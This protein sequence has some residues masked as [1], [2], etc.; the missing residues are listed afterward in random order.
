M[1]VAFKYRHYDK[2]AAS[3]D[4]SREPGIAFFTSSG[5]RI[6][7]YPK[8]HSKNL[9]A[10]HQATI[11]NF[12]KLVRVFKN[13]RGKLVDDGL[14]GK[15]IAPSYFIEGLLYNVPNDKFVG[16]YGTIVLNILQWLHQ[17]T[18]RSKFVCAN[19]QYYLLRDN[20]PVCWPVADGQQF[21]NAAI[22]LW[23]DW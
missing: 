12:K 16:S 18:D 19:E 8:Q 14:L 23:N 4:Q 6:A 11:N 7:N 20:E 15:G 3:T 17:T 9:T 2:F 1:I 13:M 10:K 22:K 5:T 21:I